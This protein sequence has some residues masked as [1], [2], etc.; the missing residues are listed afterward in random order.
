[1]TA[2]AFI[3]TGFGMGLAG[4]LHCVGMCGPLMMA[5]PLHSF[6]MAKKIIAIVL[7]HSGRLM[8]YAMLGAATG[9]V[10]RQFF[11]GGYQQA[12]SI[13]IGMVLLAT[14]LVTRRKG[15]LLQRSWLYKKVQSLMVRFLQQPSL[16][17]V[18]MMGAANGLL[19]CGMVYVAMVAAASTGSVVY[20]SLF[21]LLFGSGTIP[22]L[23]LASFAGIFFRPRVRLALKKVSPYVTAFIAVLLVLRGLNLNI[24]YLSPLL[25]LPGNEEV[26]SCH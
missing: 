11:I 26:I 13:A 16:K 9:M 2:A 18:W 24:P 15:T 14:V 6:S 20:G 1:M 3:L 5:L 19:P 21:M 7:Y 25:S 10:G 22:L 23:M 8:S 17:T 12:F 4:S